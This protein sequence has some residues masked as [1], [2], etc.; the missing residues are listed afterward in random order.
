MRP[1]EVKSQGETDSWKDRKIE[2]VIEKRDYIDSLPKMG[3]E[4]RKRFERLYL[5]SFGFQSPSEK[6]ECFYICGTSDRKIPKG[7][8]KA[9]REKTGAKTLRHVGYIGRHF[10]SINWTEYHLIVPVLDALLE[11]G[12][13][14]QV[15]TRGTVSFSSE[16]DRRFSWVAYELKLI[17]KTKYMM[18]LLDN[19]LEA[20]CFRWSDR[21]EWNY[22]TQMGKDFANQMERIARSQGL[23][24]TK[25]SD[26][27]WK[28]ALF[29]GFERQDFFPISERDISE[30]GPLFAPEWKTLL[31]DPLP[32]S[33][34]P[35]E[36]SVKIE[37]SEEPHTT[38]IV[39][40]P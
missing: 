27:M 23:P 19:D 18:N 6:E 2:R 30:Y 33:P 25:E 14:F 15:W 32:R 16:A 1:P 31:S 11:N 21:C 12:V 28:T 13:K 7:V 39:V 34:P 22:V 24:H 3:E 5:N 37:K 26:N 20:G 17:E 8:K 40:M 4:S 35:L 36:D 9:V 10:L 29:D 38:R